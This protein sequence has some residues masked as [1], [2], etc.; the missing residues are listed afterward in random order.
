MQLSL[1]LLRQPTLTLIAQ[2]EEMPAEPRVHLIQPYI[3]GG[4]TKLT[5]TR[6]PD[7]TN[8]ENILI[9]SENLLTVCDPTEKLTE[10]YLTKIGKSIE[11]MT[12]D[13]DRVLLNEGENI[14]DPLTS[15]MYNNEYEPRYIETDDL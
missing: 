1:I 6:W 8:D 7:Y 3:V 14:L 2:T 10:L 4:K 5:L 13:P 12:K 15:P 9:H 11:D